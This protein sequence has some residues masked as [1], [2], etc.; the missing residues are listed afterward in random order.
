MGQAASM[1]SEP[2]LTSTFGFESRMYSAERLSDASFA[3]SVST[4]YAPSTSAR[5]E[6]DKRSSDAASMMEMARSEP[7]SMSAAVAPFAASAASMSAVTLSM[8]GSKS[9]QR[10]IM[11]F[12]R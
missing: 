3:P 12:S 10:K 11:S 9:D 6:Y 7:V 1:R 5:W 8:T 4:R 2:L